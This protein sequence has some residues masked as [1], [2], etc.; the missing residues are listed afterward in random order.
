MAK[1]ALSTLFELAALNRS[2]FHVEYK[3]YLSNHVDHGLI[4]LFKLG[5]TPN[6]L[7]QFYQHYTRKLEPKI[8]DPFVHVVDSSLL[9]NHLQKETIQ[10]LEW[11]DLIG[12][13]R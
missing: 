10:N 8:V 7:E 2:S 13:K 6:C 12:K 9:N 11:K 4:A 5:A 1:S 3:G